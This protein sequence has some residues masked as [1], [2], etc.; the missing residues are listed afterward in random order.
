MVNTTDK[1]KTAKSGTLLLIPGMKQKYKKLPEI[2]ISG[3]KA[4]CK[5]VPETQ[6]N[7]AAEKKRLK[8]NPANPQMA[9]IVCVL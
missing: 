4:W 1:R 5:S 2:K 9:E 7:I 3:V 6:S 8:G